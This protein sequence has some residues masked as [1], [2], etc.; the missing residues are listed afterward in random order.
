LPI[1]PL[2]RRLG[3]KQARHA[4]LHGGEDY[5]LLFT[6]SLKVPL[7]KTLSGVRLTR[8]GTILR[9]SQRHPQI[10]SIAA[11]GTRKPLQPGGW[12]HFS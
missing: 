7:P 6:A 8:I 9:A 5:E 3:A 12:E 2:A 11:N 10:V 1:H 4:V